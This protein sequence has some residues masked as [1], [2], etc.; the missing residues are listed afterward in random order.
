MMFVSILSVMLSCV[1]SKNMFVKQLSGLNDTRV[2]VQSMLNRSPSNRPANY[3]KGYN[4]LSKFNGS[5]YNV[6][7]TGVKYEVSYIL[8]LDDMS[9]KSKLPGVYNTTSENVSWVFEASLFPFWHSKHSYKFNMLLFDNV[10]CSLF[11]SSFQP[12]K[13]L[14]SNLANNCG[15]QD[16]LEP[17]TPNFPLHNNQTLTVQVSKA[18]FLGMIL[19]HD[20]S[21]RTLTFTS[22]DLVEDLLY[23]YVVNMTSSYLVKKHHY[24]LTALFESNNGYSFCYDHSM[25][26]RA[27]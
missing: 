14:E 10:V 8:M 6:T 4:L 17:S 5:H 22:V 12:S 25:K 15:G 16:I 26:T 23:S 18:G 19:Y 1:F 24:E 11:S 21:Y 3:C 7:L 27:T 13:K 2:Q 20:I 9:D